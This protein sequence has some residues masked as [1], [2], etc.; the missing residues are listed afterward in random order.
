MSESSLNKG[1]SRIMLKRV[2]FRIK[3]ASIENLITERYVTPIDEYNGYFL[4]FPCL[5]CGFERKLA[6]CQNY[7]PYF[8]S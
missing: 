6:N 8:K 4:W 7:L 5:S 1:V 2:V 3:R